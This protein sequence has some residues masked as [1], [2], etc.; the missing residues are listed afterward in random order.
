TVPTASPAGRATPAS[1][2][3]RQWRSA[4]SWPSVTSSVVRP[5]ERVPALQQLP[6][7]AGLALVKALGV[8]G[9]VEFEELVVQMMTELV[10]EGAEESAEGY[11]LLALRG[12]HPH[13]HQRG[14]VLLRLVQSVQLAPVV[15][16]PGR[17]DLEAQARDPE[18]AGQ[19]VE[20]G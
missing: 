2:D 6:E 14:A 11:D 4:G 8:E 9:F 12:P 7:Q 13:R 10:D 16:R 18:A 1:E 17:V 15:R 3:C 20:Q 19:R 5:L